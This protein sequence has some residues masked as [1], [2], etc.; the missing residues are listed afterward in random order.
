MARMNRKG[1][2]LKHPLVIRCSIK[3]SREREKRVVS[4]LASVIRSA[5]TSFWEERKDEMNLLLAVDCC[6]PF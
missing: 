1:V 2:I 3:F 4:L 5:G 6:I